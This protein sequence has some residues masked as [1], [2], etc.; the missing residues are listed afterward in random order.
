MSHLDDFLDLYP[1]D[2]GPG[3]LTGR[4]GACCGH[5]LREH[6]GRL[7]WCMVIVPTERM[8]ADGSAGPVSRVYCECTGYKR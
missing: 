4:P 7:D 1:T 6:S 3:P 8:R 2:D 5:L